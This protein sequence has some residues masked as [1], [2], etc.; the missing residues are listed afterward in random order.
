MMKSLITVALAS[1]FVCASFGA[2]SAEPYNSGRDFPSDG[3]VLGYYNTTHG[4]SGRALRLIGFTG[5][6]VYPNFGTYRAYIEV[7]DPK[8]GT[9]VIELPLVKTL[10]NKRLVHWL[11]GEEHHILQKEYPSP[12][13]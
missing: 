8:G 2:L 4:S 11:I 6:S 5:L 1:L 3:M 13:K 12:E 10:D 7:E 9:R